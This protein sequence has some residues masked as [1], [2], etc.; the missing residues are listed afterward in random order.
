M[1]TNGKRGTTPQ[2]E[3]SGEQHGNG[4]FKPLALGRS[5]SCS[6]YDCTSSTYTLLIN[7]HSSTTEPK[8]WLILTTERRR[9]LFRLY[10]TNNHR[11]RHHYSYVNHLYIH[12]HDDNRNLSSN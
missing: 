1:E 8:L 9:I 2:G 5:I 11:N 7:M 6:Y 4:Q 12:H 10:S 3:S